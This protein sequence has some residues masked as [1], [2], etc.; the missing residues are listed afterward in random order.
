MAAPE[1]HNRGTT[2]PLAGASRW[3]PT[4]VRAGSH[5]LVWAMVVVPTVID[6]AGGWRPVRDDA[7][8]SIGSY[9]VFSAQSPLVGVWSLASQG[10]HHAFYDLGPLL[11]WL[12][13]VPVHLDPDHGALWGAAL[14]SGGAL[15]LAVE[16][17]W[18]VKG[19]AAAAAVALVVA[20]LG[21]QTKMFTD[22]VWN[23]HVGLV[24]L[25][26]AGTTAW[27]VASGRFGW[28]PVAVLLASVAAQCHLIYSVTA[29]A[30]A[31]IAPL[32]GL[33][34][35]HRPRRWRWLAVG[36]AAA[37]VC[38][39]PPL[40][41]QIS[42][43]PGNLSLVLDSG[44]AQRQVGLG[45]GLHALATAVTPHPIWLTPYPYA[46]SVANGMPHY[47]SSHSGAW[48][49]AVL[50]LLV[51]VA[52]VAWRTARRE[53]SALALVGAAVAAGTVVSFAAFPKDNLG[54]LDYLVN[55]LWLVGLL[56][57]I[58]VLWAGGDVA[59]AGWDR[60]F[61]GD[62]R[63]RGP[64]PIAAGLPV[65]GLLLLVLAGTAGLRALVPAAHGQAAQVRLDAP[66][67]DAIARAVEHSVPPGPVIVDVRPATFGPHYG[68]YNID[69]WGMA[70]VLLEDGW[71]PGLEHYFFGPATHLSVPSGARWPE[72]IVSVDPSTKS[73]S[74]VRRLDPTGR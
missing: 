66:L 41:Q 20:D 34:Y 26:A 70:F 56:V 67:D 16:A 47:V 62:R 61:H 31:V 28:W 65:A 60:W 73:V 2:P 30:L 51:A 44:A 3:L 6:L 68:Y 13:A 57:W 23:P 49:V 14:A 1:S 37:A 46:V 53:L 36:L 42:G 12:L 63:L 4:A 40:V 17:A 10:L 8:I 72:V 29:V 15:S 5:A 50:C 21:W 54:P 64:L 58:I 59:L 74:G 52:L 71:H 35:G 45:F 55:L 43:H 38:W 9:Q 25:L 27:V 24:F 7:M 48:G 11:F 22:L 33:A 18:S 69:F 32:A 19:W 39:G